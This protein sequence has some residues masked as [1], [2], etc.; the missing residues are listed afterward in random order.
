MNLPC[1]NF[2]VTCTI[3]PFRDPF[4]SAGILPELREFVR[5]ERYDSQ[6][7]ARGETGLKCVLQ[8]SMTPK[9]HV[10]YVL[11]NADHHNSIPSLHNLFSLSPSFL[12]LILDN[13]H[14]A[15]CSSTCFFLLFCVRTKR[16]SEFTENWIF[17][18]F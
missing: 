16:V 3:S 11:V 17:H 9:R 14:Q 2:R 4:R 8:D 7:A 12:F 1:T 10:T 13:P 5:I 6:V 18:L 15:I